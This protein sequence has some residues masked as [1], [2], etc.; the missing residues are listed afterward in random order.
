MSSRSSRRNQ[1]AIVGFAQSP[2]ARRGELWLG[3]LAV[4]TARRAIADA[5][6]PVGA[7]DGFT[8]GSVLPSTGG[9]TNRD[10]RDIVTANW[11]A[12]AL[13]VFPR[14]S[15]GFQGYGQLP[16][17]VILASQA[18]LSGSADYVV[19]HRALSNPAGKYHENDMAEAEGDAQWTAPQGFFGPPVAIAL[20]ATEYLQRSGATR[21]DLGRVV[22]EMRANGARNEWSYWRDQPVTLDDYLAARMVADPI[23]ILDCDIPIQSVTA[24]V[25]TSAERARDLP[26]RPVYVTGW[27]LG[28]PVASAPG[29]AWMVDEML[30]GGRRLAA[31]LWEHTGITLADVDH[32]QLYDGFS[33]FVLYWLEALGYCGNGEAAEFVRAGHAARLGAFHSGGSIGNGRMHGVAQMLDCYVQLSGRGGDRQLP[34]KRIGLAC[35]SS[36]HY[37]G[38]VVYSAE[39]F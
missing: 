5:G 19:V 9:H 18:I 12:E 24:F 17:S 21:E 4:D 11:L 26:H 34:G 8:T 2:V 36:P 6:L 29:M 35:H 13:G 31:N 37:G 1:V 39:Q 28:Y 16:G 15:S 23:T 32:P 14:W 22:V 27:A 7:I 20:S 30:A 38:A 3:A 33:P 25:L 10:G